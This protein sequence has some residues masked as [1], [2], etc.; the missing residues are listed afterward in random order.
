MEV[1]VDLPHIR[2][3]GERK[4]SE[5]TTVTID[6]TAVI[7]GATGYVGRLL[8]EPVALEF[9]QVRCISRHPERIAGEIPENAA[10]IF[11]DLF[12]PK[13]LEECLAGADVA[14]YLAH[15]MDEQAN[16]EEL[17]RRAAENFVAAASHAGIT[18]IIYLGALA[19]SPP[20]KESQHIASRRAVGD[21]LRSSEIDV[22][23]F[24]ASVVIGAGSMPFET[25][26]A[27]VERLPI[28][29]TPRWVRMPVQPIA[30]ADLVRYLVN[31]SSAPSKGSRVYE[32]G[33]KNVITYAR[34]MKIYARARGLRR[35]MV[36]VPVITPR[37]SSLWL[38]LVTPAHYR[39]GRRI[40][41]S[42]A[43]SS[44]ISNHAAKNDF[45]FDPITAEAA[46]REALDTE[47]SDLEFLDAPVVK[48][49]PAMKTRIG[50]KFV[51]RRTITVNVAP[52]DL[53]RTIGSIGGP[54]G[55]FWGDWLWR[56]RGALDKLVGGPGL[57]RG[58]VAANDVAVGQTLD[59]WTVV[60]VAPG[61]RITLRA[62]MRLPGEAWLDLRVRNTELG[63][64]L[65]QTVAF[66]ARGVFGVVYWFCLYPLHV[67]VFRGML[68]EIGSRARALTSED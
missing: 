30:A 6:K 33:G 55:W 18:R 44:I 40:V 53:Y 14:F 51:E 67:L 28:M 50:T 35:L 11:G 52:N 60:R 41:D 48:N 26:R 32:I 54:N 57:R 47:N 13:S 56:F 25:I 31:A 59:F 4:V 42:A 43:H 1:T 24:R 37:L 20:E 46:V 65:D 38:K 68:R 3:L 66:D 21:V 61:S 5:I 58:K 16:Y 29:V 8:I 45:G 64:A 63:V 49:S 12:D 22:I 27:L 7:I 39:I 62:D 2:C 9:S 36:P 23:E 10:A 19:Q 34:L 17:E 15:S